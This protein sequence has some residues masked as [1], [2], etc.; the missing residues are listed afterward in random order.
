MAASRKFV[1]S[2]ERGALRL[3]RECAEAEMEGTARAL[4]DM[5]RELAREYP[6]LRD[7]HHVS[8]V[9]AAHV[10]DPAYGDEQSHRPRTGFI[11]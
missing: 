6:E 10:F 8:E 7:Y 1:V 3:E 5:M 4:L 11:R 9:P 2:V